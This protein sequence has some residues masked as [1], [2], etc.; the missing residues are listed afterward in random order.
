MK[1]VLGLAAALAGGLF[2]FS[3]PVTAAD[4]SRYVVENLGRGVIALRASDTSV[5]V[6][7]RLLGTDPADL[8]FNVYRSTDGGAP[9][10][11]NSQPLT[12]TTD[13][14]DT[15]VDLTR[16]NS[17]TVRPVLKGT[18]LAA[19]TPFVLAANS[20]VQQYLTV[21]LQRPAGG[22]VEVP[23]GSPTSAFTYSPNDASVADLDG[24]G[25]YEIILKWD[26]SN[27]RD[28]ASAGL[29]GPVL[30]DAYKLD[31]TLLWRINLGRNIRAGAHY[32]QFMVY[33]LDGDGRAEVA[34]KT[35]DGTVDGRGT[36]IGDATKDYRS[37][38]VPTDG[39]QVPATNDARYGK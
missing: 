36:V 29:S 33:D 25:E 8:A 30:V 24:D 6:G 28:S 5:Y 38:T 34:M 22:N 14:V 16:A 27:S 9:A 1:H 20:P 13:L 11:L 39:I 7:W 4:E 3:R 18:E 10:K 35:A 17:Y 26:P 21:P 15:T 19:S 23:D 12:A 32:T 2:L 31:G 37:L